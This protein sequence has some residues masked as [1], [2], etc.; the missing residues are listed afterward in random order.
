MHRLRSPFVPWAAYS[1]AAIVIGYYAGQYLDR[2][3]PGGGPPSPWNGAWLLLCAPI[4]LGY[5]LID[6]WHTWAVGKFG[7]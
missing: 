4:P 3:S 6:R 7:R 1:I 2:P 5:W